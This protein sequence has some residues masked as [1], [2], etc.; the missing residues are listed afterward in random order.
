MKKAKKEIEKLIASKKMY[1]V[2]HNVK[3]IIN[4]ASF[5]CK[6]GDIIELS[7]FEASILHAYVEE[8]TCR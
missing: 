1:K 8:V 7:D 6:K 3:S 5:D 4:S 2:T